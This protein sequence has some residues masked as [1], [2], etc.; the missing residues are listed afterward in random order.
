MASRGRSLALGISTALITRGISAI[1]PLLLIPL[2]LPYLGAEVFGAWMAIASIVGMLIWADMGLGNSLLT[3]LTRTVAEGKNDKARKLIASA[4]GLVTGITL[5]V[6]CALLIGYFTVPF[7]RV[8][9][10]RD[11]SLSS[12]IQNVAL[13]ALTAFVINIPLGLIQRIQYAFGEVSR[14]NVFTGLGSVFSVAVVGLL[15]LLETPSEGVILIASSG[16]IF[17]NLA[18]TVSFF[19]RRPALRPRLADCS[20]R[21]AGQLFR[22][23]RVFLVLSMLV[24]AALSCD[25]VIIANAIDASA[26]TQFSVPSRVFGALGMMITLVNLPLW[27][28]NGEALAAGDVAWVR[29]I[30]ER[31]V[32]LSGTSVLAASILLITYGAKVSNVFSGGVVEP[33]QWLV[34][35]LGLWWV[36][37]AA[38]SPLAMVQNA[39][40]VLRPQLVG[41]VLFLFTTIPIKFY[42]VRLWGIESVPFVGL[43][44]YAATVV[45]FLYIGYRKAISCEVGGSHSRSWL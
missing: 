23:G 26:V 25:S 33:N 14:S 16:P 19:G 35:G 36:A 1:A 12:Q 34:L 43:A 24:A 30:T 2:T 38:V 13:V 18:S 11:G 15:V 37:V 20:S 45:P 6:M 7:Y 31:M 44:T 28:A 17:A 22:M 9:G 21:D 5:A 32:V 40:G 3:Q 39:A 42:F 10:I 29:R 41:W 8:V 4:Y 27:P